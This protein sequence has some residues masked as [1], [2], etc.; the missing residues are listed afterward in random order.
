M[1]SF[2][3]IKII[4]TA[5]V[6]M[7]L[8]LASNSAHADWYYVT[9]SWVSNG[10]GYFNLQANDCNYYTTVQCIDANLA[11]PPNGHWYSDSGNYFYPQNSGY[12]RGYGTPIDCG[13]TCSPPD[14]NYTVYDADCGQNNGRVIVDAY[15]GGASSHYYAFAGGN[16]DGPYDTYDFYNLSPGQ[17]TFYIASNPHEASCQSYFTVT[18]GGGNPPNVS[19]GS[20]KS[21]CAGQSVQLCASGA[22]S[23]S[24]SNGSNSQC[25]NVSPNSSTTYSVTGTTNGCSDSDNV[26]VYVGN[27]PNVNAGSNKTICRGESVQLCASG[28]SNYS[29]S[30]GSN[31]QCINVSPNST[32]TY[33][34]TGGNGN[35]TDSDNVTVFVNPSPNVTTTGGSICPGESIQIC[36]SGASSYTWSN[37][38][39]G[40]CI[41]VSPN[42]T[43]TYTVTGRNNNNCEDTANA[44]VVVEGLDVDIDGGG[45]VCPLE[46]GSGACVTLT[47]TGDPGTYEWSNGQTTQSICVPGEGTYSVTVTDGLCTGIASTTVS[48]TEVNIDTGT[49]PS[50]CAGESVTIGGDP[51]ADDGADYEWSTGESGTISDFFLF[52]DNGQITVSP[53]TTTSYSV[54]V[55]DNGC[56][57]VGTVVVAVSN[58]DGGVIS[59]EETTVCI[60]SSLETAYNV[61][62]TGASNDN[63]QWVITDTDL[64]IVALP[65]GEPLDLSGLDQDTDYLIWHLSYSD[66]SGAAI[67]ANAGDLEGCFDLSNLIMIRKEECCTLSVNMGEDQTICE[68]ESATITGI[69]EN[70]VVC[71]ASGGPSYLW[72]NGGTTPSQVVSPAATTTYSVTVT[73]CN[74]IC[75]A[76]GSVTVNVETGC[77]T[78]VASS[79]SIAPVEAGCDAYV[80]E[81][82]IN[83]TGGNNSQQYTTSYLL[84]DALGNI[85]NANTEPIFDVMEAA[86]YI[87]H[88]L[89]FRTWGGI[90]GQTIFIGENIDNV[91]G[92]CF[93]LSAG[94]PLE[95]CASS[96]NQSPIAINDDNV[97]FKEDPI[98]GNVLNNDIDPD[99]DDL[100]INTTPINSPANGSV[101][102]YP[103]G[104][105]F[106]IP[107]EGFVG[108]DVF[109]YEIC[110]TGTP[111][112]CTTGRVSITVMPGMMNALV[113][114]ND[115][116]MGAPDAGANNLVN[117]GNQS[118]YKSSNQAWTGNL[119]VNDAATNGVDL[120]MNT[121]PVIV[122]AHG[123]VMLYADGSYE[124]TPD[125][126][127]FGEDEFE[128]EVCTD[129]VVP[130][131]G[132]AKMYITVVEDM[133]GAPFAGDDFFVINENTNY[134]AGSV[135]DNDYDTD[136]GTCTFAPINA[137]DGIIT[138]E[139]GATVTVHADG[140][141]D[142]TP[143]A[144]YIGADAFC[145]TI[146]DDAGNMHKG[147]A[148]IFVRRTHAKVDLNIF[149]AGALTDATNMSTGI[150]DRGL[151]PGQTPTSNLATPTP[152]G[153]PYNVAPWNYNGTEGLG[154]TDADYDA[155]EA[156]EGATVVDWVLVTFRTDIQANTAVGQ[157]AGLLLNDGRVVFPEHTLALDGL[158]TADLY[159]VIDHRN[160]MGVMSPVAVGMTTRAEMALDLRNVDSYATQTGIGQSEIMSGVWAMPAGDASK[161]TDLTGYDINGNDKTI[162]DTDNGKFDSYF[163]GDFN[164]DGD[165]NGGD[166]ALWSDNNGIFSNVPK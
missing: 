126:G 21:I 103:S 37:G 60:G 71:D 70:F 83:S 107:N 115:D 79:I 125:A 86:S 66:I 5:L 11:L 162:W 101:Q 122:P 160:H 159:M 111:Q 13:P 156:T 74:N 147:T 24:W 127:Y 155:I 12:Q 95:V 84:T 32:T 20:D 136:G 96:V 58:P 10:T 146:T 108:T 46:G 40:S 142:Y 145:Y 152:A 77:C 39:S 28:A 81:I 118:V 43:T 99:G 98:F 54:T 90:D 56:S 92:D 88:S 17:Y 48:F 140:T 134:Y 75:V 121:T 123:T 55:T 61:N 164:M 105:Y 35:C 137:V 109:V 64:N 97:T 143:L 117:N 158:T 25:I 50:I 68:G 93:E 130:V 144:D 100:V 124:Y 34:V 106:Y 6:T 36:A 63:S 31:S 80:G 30:N 3:L 51:L 129:E 41:T 73:D 44:T 72:S 4:N 87:V 76:T 154:W 161:V 85:I 148:N 135:A 114:N 18:V 53:T 33:T 166:K 163:P 14:A 42:S 23:Y 94:M 8:M 26:T 113:L 119:I 47:A 116:V 153:Q 69:A 139:K 19:A 65:A 27:I 15:G 45:N 49:N 138:T 132:T 128:Y 2:N 150:N 165:V 82:L 59:A 133:N 9:N 149:L 57:V 91:S 38:Q 16:Y 1:K 78:P 120:I 89:N 52:G 141:F 22:S 29:W 110:D 131:C 67:G 157:A 151:L 102:L 104:T 7:L 112:E 62:L